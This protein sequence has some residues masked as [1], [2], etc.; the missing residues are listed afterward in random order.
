M[1]VER[2]RIRKSSNQTTV[3]RINQLV[4][5]LEGFP[6]FKPASPPLLSALYATVDS[7]E[8][9]SG[10]SLGRVPFDLWVPEFGQLGDGGFPVERARAYTSANVLNGCAP[11]L[12][13]LLRHL[14]LLQAHGFDG[15]LPR[16]VLPALHDETVSQSINED[17]RVLDA[18]AACRSPS[19]HHRGGD[20]SV[21]NVDQLQ[22]VEPQ[23][24]ERL[25]KSIGEP[26][27]SFA[28]NVGAW[29]RL[30][31]AGVVDERR[32]KDR[33][34]WLTRVQRLKAQSHDLHVL[35]RHLLL[36]QAYGFEGFGAASRIELGANNPSVAHCPDHGRFQGD[37]LSVRLAPTV[38]ADDG[39]DAV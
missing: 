13:V 6:G 3:P 32:V 21:A 12:H 26:F 17:V 8:V 10:L 29:V 25:Q 18:Y 4:L 34:V 30:V 35:L 31:R 1:P 38:I 23:V 24:A 15:L 9:N 39:H 33:Q 20:H 27:V 36:R 37:L 2:P 7:L 28:A 16:P 19:V 11:R 14:L 5:E 22:H